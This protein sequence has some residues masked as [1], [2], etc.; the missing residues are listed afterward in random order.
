MD[1]FN[2]D[3]DHVGDF[4]ERWNASVRRTRT[5]TIV[6]GVLLVLAGIAS[7]VAPLS[8]YA[9][10]Q[11]VVAAALIA[12]GIGETVSYART[13]ELFRSPTMLVMGVLNALLGVMLLA[14][15]AYLT[16]GTVVFLLAFLFIISGAERITY[17]RRMRYFGLPDSGLTTFTGVLNVVCGVA[18]LLMPAFSGVVIG[19]V[20][21][22]YLIVGGA[23][24]VVEGVSMR[25]IER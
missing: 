5:W 9:L 21:A 13:P 8:I 4:V 17:A 1:R 7:A 24:L 22:A 6:I 2:S 25:P 10:I 11:G 19:Y 14:L 3:F 23:S 16:A 20:I 12:G 18:F 15:P